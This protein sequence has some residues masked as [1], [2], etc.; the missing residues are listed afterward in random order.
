[1]FGGWSQFGEARNVHMFRFLTILA[2]CLALITVPL[3]AQDKLSAKEFEKLV[4]K[5][6][7]PLFIEGERVYRGSEVTRR[8][9]VTLKPEPMFTDK[10]RQKKIHGLVEF[11]AIFNASGE[12]RVLN[13]LKRLPHGLTEEALKASAQIRFKPALLDGEPVSQTML[14]QYSFNR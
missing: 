14:L 13:V 5:S 7:E 3:H 9:I 6:T 4:L 12:V 1:M 2:I 11:R 8:V 10:A